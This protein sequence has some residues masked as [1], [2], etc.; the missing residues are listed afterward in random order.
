VQGTK[1]KQQLLVCFIHDF[2]CTKLFL[3]MA[4]PLNFELDASFWGR[5]GRGVWQFLI[6]WTS[7]ILHSPEP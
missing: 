1:T 5:W 4:E 6:V 2:L 3:E 7:N